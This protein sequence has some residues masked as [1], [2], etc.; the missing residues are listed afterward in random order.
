[1]SL[2]VADAHVTTLE[3]NSIALTIA[4][5][6]KKAT[7]GGA[8]SRSSAYTSI[9]MMIQKISSLQCLLLERRVD[10]RVYEDLLLLNVSLL[11][12]ILIYNASN[13]FVIMLSFL[14]VEV[15]L[16]IKITTISWL[17]TSGCAPGHLT[18]WIVTPHRSIG[19]NLTHDLTS[20]SKQTYSLSD[21]QT[22]YWMLRVACAPN[23]RLVLVQTYK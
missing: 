5:L 8:S 4:R 17:K 12:H 23:K 21:F 11:V 22:V 10:K 16:W 9:S 15:F 3:I 7:A 13:K 2:Q 20:L 19:D 14:H 18:A 6:G 1:M